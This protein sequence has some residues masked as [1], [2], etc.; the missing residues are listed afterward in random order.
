MDASAEPGIAA[1]SSTTAGHDVK[2]AGIFDQ[3]DGLEMMLYTASDGANL[4]A[5][6]SHANHD[7]LRRQSHQNRAGIYRLGGE[8]RPHARGAQGID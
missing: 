2:I 3:I 8:E 1:M 5:G 7:C 6:G 4:D